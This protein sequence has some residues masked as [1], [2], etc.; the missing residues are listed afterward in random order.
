MGILCG[1]IDD[2]AVAISIL[3]SYIAKVPGLE[4][5]FTL[6]N[7]MESKGHLDKFKPQV[8]FLDVEMPG[9]SG[10]EL[11]YTLK[12]KPAVVITSAKKDYAA[13]GF[14]LEVFDYIVKPVTF[15]RFVKSIQK[16]EKTIV[17]HNQSDVALSDWIFVN[18]NK[19]M[20]K[21]H[22]AD[23]LYVESLKDYI[24]IHTTRR[25]VI[26]KDQISVFA[27]KLPLS[28]FLRIHRSF[29]VAINHIDSFNASMVEI[30]GSELPIG[31]IYKNDCIK[32][33]GNL[34]V[35]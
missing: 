35:F 31:R 28:Q 13:E 32:I 1:I 3:Q 17:P 10:I 19:K 11:L 7:A 2:D 8:L 23:I 29:L 9:L 21:I 16:Y 25:S 15:Q 27:D 26:T 30:Q 12:E 20:V 18:E 33:L 24:K 4:L 14:E 6:T 34:G 22:I 5:A